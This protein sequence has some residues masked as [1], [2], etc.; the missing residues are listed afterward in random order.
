[1]LACCNM[2]PRIAVFVA[3]IQGGRAVVSKQRPIEPMLRYQRP[4]VQ[5][6]KD[7]PHVVSHGGIL[8]K[9]AVDVDSGMK[10]AKYPKTGLYSRMHSLSTCR[11]K[12]QN[13]N[14]KTVRLPEHVCVAALTSRQPQNLVFWS[15]RPCFLNPRSVRWSKNHYLAI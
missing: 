11:C 1:M 13:S 15:Y 9:P 7:R 14:T 12:Y 2:F 10:E 3:M 4:D 8:E 5:L 6:R